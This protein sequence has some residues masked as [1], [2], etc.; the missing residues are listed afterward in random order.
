MRHLCV[1]ESTP[2]AITDAVVTPQLPVQRVAW[3]AEHAVWPEQAARVGDSD[4][5]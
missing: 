3:R 4:L 2:S 5:S 1:T